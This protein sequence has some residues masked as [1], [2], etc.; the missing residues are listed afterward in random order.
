MYET[1]IKLSHQKKRKHLFQ[2]IKQPIIW[3]CT[4]L[5]KETILAASDFSW[6]K[7][8]ILTLGPAKL[9]YVFFIYLF[10]IFV[11]L[12]ILTSAFLKNT[13]SLTK[14]GPQELYTGLQKWII[15]H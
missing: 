14:G 5:K 12:F 2:N 1:M 4:T 11:F 6:F 8:N 15:F 13:H 7:V 3:T 10:K 9:I